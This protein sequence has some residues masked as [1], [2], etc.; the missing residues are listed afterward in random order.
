M[1]SGAVAAS[2][3]EARVGFWWGLIQRVPLTEVD[4]RCTLCV[5]SHVQGLAHRVVFERRLGRHVGV[6]VD[7][8][9]RICARLK[10]FRH[11]GTHAQLEGARERGKAAA[12][13]SEGGSE[14]GKEGSRV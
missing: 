9:T 5:V 1:N 7:G 10:A 4:D 3:E 6:G 8:H 11:A 13:D 12:G 14:A 2:A